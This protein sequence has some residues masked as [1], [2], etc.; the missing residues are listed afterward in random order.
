MGSS[1]ESRTRQAGGSASSRARRST[2]RV[3]RSWPNAA[4][5]TPARTT[6]GTPLSP[7]RRIASS[8]SS[9]RALRSAPRRAGTTQNA[10]RRVQPSW[11]FRKARVLLGV[12][13][14]LERSSRRGHREERGAGRVRGRHDLPG[15]EPGRV[16]VENLG[17]RAARGEGDDEIDLRHPGEGFARPLRRGNR[18]RR[19]S[20]RGSRAGGA[21]RGAGRRAR[22]GPSR[23]SRARGG[24]PRSAGP[25]A[26]PLADIRERRRVDPADLAAQGRAEDAPGRNALESRSLT[27]RS[28][29]R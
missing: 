7:R 27:R 18:R 2:R 11:I 29:C 3:P 21:A 12:D 28:P 15:Q 4:R 13:E 19:A 25:R 9:G 8:T 17:E 26:R 20:R 24:R 10:Q 6:S 16:R 5:W 1:D 14:R 22:R 23:R